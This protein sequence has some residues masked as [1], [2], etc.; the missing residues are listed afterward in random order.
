[1]NISIRPCLASELETLQKIGYET[2]DDTFRAWNKPENIDHYLAEAFHPERLFTELS[3]PD[4]HF[5]FLFVEDDLAGYIKVNVAPAQS[6]LNDPQSL[7]IERIY[8][9]KSYKG[10]GLG[11]RLMD[12][13][14]QL[15][16]K[17]GK[18]YA[19]LGVWD[20][21]SDAIAFYQKMGFTEVGR[22]PFML[23]DDLQTDLIMR[24][25]LSNP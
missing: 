2:F 17:M 7:E 5:F 9:R 16:V 8:V 11:T 19:W 14:L 22:H 23:G 21:N 15:A 18:R 6:D 24:K 3:N 10:K 25:E 12:Y 1:M 4:S 20:R 13:A